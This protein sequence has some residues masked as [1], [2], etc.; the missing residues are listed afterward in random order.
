MKNVLSGYFLLIALALFSI[1]RSLNAQVL[2]VKYP[3]KF[4]V[5]A[6]LRDMKPV[7]NSSR[8][9]NDE[10]IVPNR[11]KNIPINYQAPPDPALQIMASG[12]THQPMV[13]NPILNFDGV[14]NSSNSGRVTPPD[15]TG[16]VGPNHYVQVV[17]SMLQ[18]YNKSGTSLYGPVTTSTI[19]SGF[20]GNWNGHNDGDAIVLY[21]ENADRWLIAQFA[22][23]CGSY[24]SYTEY[25]LVAIS[26]TADPTG[27][28]YR[29]AFQLDYM[30]DY[31]KLGVWQDGYY[32]AVNRF[33]TNSG[34]T[35]FIGAAGCVLQRSKM[36][37]GDASAAMIY[38]KT[39]TLG[40]SGSGLGTDC[41]AML[42][43][44]CDGTFP[45]AG[46]PN[47][48]TY[49]NDNSGGGASELR[50]W[51]LHVDWVTTANSTFTF[52]TNLPV[53]TYTMLGTGTGVVAQSG[54]TN[55]LD[56][57]GDR[58]M[59]RN[60]YRNFGSYESFVTCHSVNIGSGVAGVR[61]YEYRKTGTT[62]S[63]TQQSS[64]NPGDG[65]SRW[66]GSIAQNI[67][68]DMA[69]AYT[70]SSSS[71]FPSIYFTGR[72]ASD[73]VSTMTV[74]EGIIQT[75]AASMTGATRW[76]DYA[77]MSVDPSD[78]ITFWTT[79]EYVGT[80]GGSWPWS[81]KIASLKWSNQPTATTT[82]ATTVTATTAVLNGTVN[83]NGLASTYHF[84]W[85]TTVAYGTS[86][87]TLSA[88][89]GSTTTP[90]NASLSGLTAG[91]TYHF[92][93]AATNSDGTSYGA[94][95]TFTP[96]AANITTTAASAI[97]QTTATAGG[98][99]V[100]D[101][102]SSVSARGTC[103]STAANPTITDS[104][105]T[106][107]SGLGAFTSSLTGL[108]S[109]TTYHIRAYATNSTSTFYGADLTF[110]TNCGNS[111][112]PFTESFSGTT[113]PSCWSQVDHQ[114]NGQIWLFGTITG[115][116][117]LPALTGNYAYLNS[118]AYGTGNTQ[119]ADLITPTID[120]T[121]FTAVTLKFN[122][123]FRFYTGST[124]TVSYS[125]N[126]GST[127]T[128]IQTWTA[129]TTNPAAF[130]Q[131]IA[132]LAGQSQVKIK[133]NFTGTYAYYWA[134]DDVQITGTSSSPTLAVTPPNQNVTSTAGNTSF[135]VTSNMSWTVTSNQ[136]WCTVTPSGS[137][138]GTITATYTDNLAGSPRVANVTTTVTG[139]T[140]IVTTV[141]QAAFVP[142][143]SVTPPNQNV[144]STAG[145]T[146]FTVTS[147]SAW[148]VTSNQTWCTVTPSGSGNGTITATYTDNLTG[149][150]RVANV[151]TTVT[152]LTSIVT[153]VTQAALVPTLAVTP[154]N[155][156]V[157]STAGTTPFTVTSNSAWTVTSNQTWCTVTPSGSGNGTITATYTD[158]LTGSTRVANV[159]T[160]VTGLTSIVTTVTQSAVVPTLAV[161]PPNQSVPAPA[162]TTTFT[163]A[164]NS[165][166]TVTSDQTWCT[167]TPSGSGNGTITVNYAQN[168]GLASRLATITTTITGLS[169]TNTVTQAGVAPTLNVTPPNQNVTA[170]AGNTSFT[171][172]SN[173][174]WTV[175]SDQ[176]WCI[177]TANGNGNGTIN[178]SF[179]D[180]T[181]VAQRVANLTVTVAGIVPIVVTV[182]Q[183]GVTPTLNVT[184]LNQD[185]AFQAG[186]TN[187]TV[188]SNT[189]W[190]VVSNQTW[191]T[192]TP[193]GTGNGTITANFTENSI[194][195]PRVATITVSVSGLTPIDVTV[196]QDGY[197]GIPELAKEDITIV[198]N[199]TDGMFTINTKHLNGQTLIVNIYDNTG[200]F[201]QSG[202]Y[203]GSKS[204]QFDFSSKPRGEYMIRISTENNNIIKKL[205]LK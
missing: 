35:P 53:T 58:L 162:G 186:S 75:G 183:G 155:Q 193:S 6:P 68:G 195:T 157:T 204:Y 106:D 9:E 4:D 5:S 177:P 172:T 146:P 134:I 182:T 91:V 25:E 48:F 205:I 120:M 117:P 113:I 51:A 44:D 148:T 73:P 79:N 90:E 66:L 28:Y 104:H 41:Y 102:G 200:R 128:T 201:I 76:G 116:T 45:A 194:T 185:V 141:T 31:P 125:I 2:E 19:W 3:V 27:T 196:S 54:T 153:T 42:P 139:L 11:I 124:A 152:G 163:V 67:N 98:V 166:W 140:P 149:S 175:V 160:T 123:Y 189:N 169:V 36:L 115:V 40:G 174:Y 192:V 122:H 138:N 142:T 119:N 63:V 184:P 118:D 180:N 49:I 114:G 150:P 62:F 97:T 65:K 103:W 105:T 93:I 145:T 109:N 14:K 47:Y 187:F 159:T 10:R 167:V 198:P 82:D 112:L 191:C 8:R 24:P 161:T 84:E 15:P 69:L 7:K 60:Q 64:F 151:T 30:P 55:K 131:V 190:T 33:N 121:G 81:T 130:N 17:N 158:N 43:S 178:A 88:G 83:P 29:Y 100:T 126:N 70:V 99:V 71:M 74:T 181:S 94:D 21:D 23:D 61:W 136:T 1:P 80:Y 110:T 85:G 132:A 59:F 72:R 199:P 26:T 164:S 56:G 168:T 87:T 144:T 147:N 16:D 39:E 50:I 37:T 32:M 108:V 34:S 133:W 52:V 171:V 188:T 86:T 154:P 135:T 38:F 89:S 202:S 173:S 92:R 107:G 18:M 143:L 176:A 203:K 197:V 129:S 156:N 13:T 165:A 22:I 78:N 179:T 170:P 95:F 77:A 137:G 57:L 12:N 20:S 96:G 127:W 111:T 46:T 101:G